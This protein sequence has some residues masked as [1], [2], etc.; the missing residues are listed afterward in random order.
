MDH[1]I[2][3]VEFDTNF[4]GLAFFIDLLNLKIDIF[5]TEDHKVVENLEEGVKLAPVFGS[6]LL[7]ELDHLSDESDA[8]GLGDRFDQVI[9]LSCRDSDLSSDV[10]H[11]LGQCTLL[12]FNLKLAQGELEDTRK[13]LLDVFGWTVEK[14]FP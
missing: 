5:S 8:D 14:D 7:Q 10:Y 4:V 13:I 9:L 6:S 3:E 1:I 12:F 11:L 2:L